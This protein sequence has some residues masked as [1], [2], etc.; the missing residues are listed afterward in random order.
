MFC[1]EKWEEEIEINTYESVGDSHNT[2]ASLEER[3]QTI[4]KKFNWYMPCN[5]EQK[6]NKD[7][8]MIAY[9]LLYNVS[10]SPSNMYTSIDKPM[11]IDLNLLGLKTGL[12]NAV[13]EL[14]AEETGLGWVP[15]INQTY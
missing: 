9:Y 12:D 3:T 5:F 10:H 11:E 6:E 2:S 13:L 7:K 1:H 8:D 4:K 15:K 14:K